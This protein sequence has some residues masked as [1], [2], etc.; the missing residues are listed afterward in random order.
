MSDF[1]HKF[2]H[3]DSV[4]EGVGSIHEDVGLEVVEDDYDNEDNID[5][6]ALKRDTPMEWI[7]PEDF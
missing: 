2:L 4:E 3:P 7:I 1:L 5:Y 6:E